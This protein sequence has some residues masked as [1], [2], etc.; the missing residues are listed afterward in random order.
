MQVNFLLFKSLEYI[1]CAH[2]RRVEGEDPQGTPS[3]ADSHA[4]SMES[5]DEDAAG[6]L[7]SL[8]GGLRR[9]PAS[10]AGKEAAKAPAAIEGP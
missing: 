9:P 1:S 10:A 6:T 5:F 2:C 8:L 7:G 4:E 3:A